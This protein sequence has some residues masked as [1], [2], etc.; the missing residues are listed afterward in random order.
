MYVYIT[1]L[2]QKDLLLEHRSAKVINATIE[3]KFTLENIYAT[4]KFRIEK[5]FPLNSFNRVVVDLFSI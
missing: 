1:I 5:V 4:Q 2:E 3:V